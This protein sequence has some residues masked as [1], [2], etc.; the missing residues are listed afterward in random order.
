MAGDSGPGLPRRHGLDLADLAVFTIDSGGRVV[1]WPLSAA[2]LFGHPA[3]SMTG[4]D[5]CD[6]LLTGPGQR[7]L[8]SRA[9]AAV[10]DSRVFTATVAGGN[11][12]EGRFEIR[13]EPL[14]GPGAGPGAG[15]LVAAQRAEQRPAWL[16]EATA[17]I[18]TSLDLFQTAREVIDAAVPRFA[19]AGAIYVAERVV[20]AHE[21]TSP[22]ISQQ[23]V[24]RRLAS[25]LSGGDPASQ[26]SL[27]RTGEVIVIGQ[28]TPVSQAMATG[29]PVRFDRLDSESVQR[30]ARRPGGREAAARYASFLAVPLTARTVV[31]C[32]LF[33]REPAS[34]PFNQADITL[35][36]ALGSR[37]AVC[38]DNAR[39]YQMELRAA[40]ALQRALVPRRAP[41]PP[42]LEIAHRCLP[43]QGSAVGGDWFDVSPLP[44]GR[45]ALIVGDAMGHGPEAAAAMLQFRTAAHSL[46]QLGLPP[47]ELLRQ[48][49]RLAADMSA[50]PFATCLAAVIDPSAGTCVAAQAGHVPPILVLP[51][52]G[53][54]LLEFPP[55]L[56]LGL[57]GGCADHTEVSVPPGATLALYTDGLVES[58]ARP[59]DTGLAELRAA[60]SAALA[61]PGSDLEGA[62]GA[63]TRAL[64]AHG[65]DD[66]TLLLARIRR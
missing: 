34:P 19:D 47:G 51:G 15:A 33:A 10:R 44:S 24:V 65:E 17:R 36:S 11:L 29:E 2:R 35:A 25:R 53:T 55:G 45:T 59:M 43:V 13:I 41:D 46:S 37:A 3:A 5:L 64:S 4:H 18:G 54:E 61:E 8:V 58:R 31:G 52:G 60:L 40:R 14:A 1:S 9:L 66:I 26:E 16:N 32:A 21:L 27:L 39:L 6:V 48:L 57:G 56:P 38:I 7:E 30:I 49:D 22:G 50:A 23:V 63:I 12:G 20:A 28:A 42:G 62:C